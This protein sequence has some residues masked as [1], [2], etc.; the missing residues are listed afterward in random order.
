[1]TVPSNHPQR[2]EG[3]GKPEEGFTEGKDFG[4]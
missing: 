2:F 4:E 1:M 3:L